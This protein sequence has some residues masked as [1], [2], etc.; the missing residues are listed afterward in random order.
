M[1]YLQF[2]SKN[3]KGI[4]N[5]TL[6]VSNPPSLRVFTLVGLNESGKTT[7]LEAINNLKNLDAEPT[8]LIPKSRRGNFTDKIVLYAEFELAYNDKKKITE[9]FSEHFGLD[10]KK[11]EDMGN[12]TRELV[13]EDSNYSGITTTWDIKLKANVEI[14]EEAAAEVEQTPESAAE[15]KPTKT[16]PVDNIENFLSEHVEPKSV[17]STKTYLL[18]LLPKIIYYPNF[19]FDFPE[20]LY[21][22]R[23]TN[24]G[25]EKK[26][27]FYRDLI[28][29]ILNSLD[30]DLTIDKHL[31]K[32]KVSGTADDQENIEKVLS[33]MAGK[34]THE[35]FTIWSRVSG[36]DASEISVTLG[37]DIKTDVDDNGE[38][39]YYIEMKVKEG[40]DNYFIKERS[41]GFRWFFA[42][43]LFTQFRK[44][45]EG[46][47]EN[48]LFLID[49][50]ASNLHQTGQQELLN[51]MDQVVEGAM[52]IYS[53]HSHHLIKPDWLP[54]A[55]IVKN[56]GLDYDSQSIKDTYNPKKTNIVA[57]P[58]HQFVAKY[59]NE[60]T[61]FKPI[62]DAL[63]YRPSSLEAV[64]DVVITEG[65]FDRY[66]F[67]YMQNVI[68]G[69]KKK[70]QINF[71][72]GAGANKHSPTISHYLSWGTKFLAL[73][74]SD[75]PGKRAIRLYTNEF[76]KDVDNRLFSF[77]DI[78][79]S[80]D[81]KT[82]EELFTES[83]RMRICQQLDKSLTT[84]DK[85]QFNISIQ[86]LL[87]SKKSVRISQGTR[88]KFQEIFSFL[89]NNL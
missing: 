17:G 76:G 46:E 79:P 82:I 48:T 53:T 60:E 49:E 44:Y 5:L 8:R 78:D 88:K 57:I 85:R 34:I 27:K 65:K 37:N 72:P 89:K 9:Y 24:A 26:Q 4:R 86:E 66:I 41:L 39:I 51:S 6:D 63:D 45:R 13:Y 30:Q 7:V 23:L 19:L 25:K 33:D 80:L 47:V 75:R 29:D 28:Q 15:P 36:I 42:F 22:S 68:L 38:Q 81:N 56:R 59:P 16:V 54:G 62:L 32:R 73:F 11:I 10:I 55:S 35:V 1:R 50:P 52:V 69:I 64:P 67:R 70:D 84:F 74:D 20:K 3:F 61:H 18:S 58:Y 21:L 77:S 14:P 12:M 43:L 31:I 2:Q 71:Y 40:T 87:V 83:E